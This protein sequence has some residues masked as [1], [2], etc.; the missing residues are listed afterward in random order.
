[1]NERETEENIMKLEEKIRHLKK[2]LKELEE[3]LEGEKKNF[4]SLK[5]DRFLRVCMGFQRCGF[6]C[7]KYSEKS[8][9]LRIPFPE[10]PEQYHMDVTVHFFHEFDLGTAQIFFHTI[11]KAF[12][13]EVEKNTF[14]ITM[15]SG[16]ETISKKF[17][18]NQPNDV[19]AQIPSMNFN[20]FSEHKDELIALTKIIIEDLLSDYDYTLDLLR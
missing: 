17:I 5:D 12:D 15:I 8:E 19:L 16:G 13:A 2:N 3:E 10:N 18:E 6:N 7:T 9:F 20:V 4:Q 1:M 14:T 11:Y